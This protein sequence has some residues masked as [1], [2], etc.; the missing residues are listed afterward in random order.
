M[1]LERTPLR[2][3]GIALLSVALTSCAQVIGIEDFTVDEGAGNASGGGGASGSSTGGSSSSGQP[4]N[5]CE[6]VHGCTRGAAE[7][8]TLNANVYIDFS[9]LGYDPQCIVVKEGSTVI[10]QST[11]FTFGDMPIQGGVLGM[12]DME[13]PMQNPADMTAKMA[14]F[15][16]P[17]PGECAYPYYSPESGPAGVIFIEP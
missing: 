4:V 17:V 8:K 15:P 16:L 14:S 2:L 5:I 9:P 11:S 13:S 1:T 7:D 3:F 10:F 12:P 6:S